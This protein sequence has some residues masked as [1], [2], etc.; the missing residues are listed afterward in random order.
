MARKIRPEDLSE[1]ELRR[2]LIARRRAARQRRLDAFRESG[3]LVDIA[4]MLGT[5]ETE[6]LP[7]IDLP[8]PLAPRDEGAEKAANRKK[9]ADRALLFVEVTAILGLFF[10]LFNGIGAVREL[11]AQVAAALIQPSLTPTPLITVA[12]LPSGHTPPTDPGGAQPNF[13]EIP[14]HLPVDREKF[15]DA[16]YNLPVP[17]PSPEQA[18]RI[19]IPAINIDAPIVQGDGWEQLKQ[20]VAQHLNTARPGED[21]NLVLS[22]HNDI[23][24]EIFRHLDQL[25]PGDEIIVYTN[26]RAYTYIISEEYQVVPPTQIDVMSQTADPTVTLISCYPYL[27]NDKRIVVTASLADG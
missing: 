11:N 13:A 8:D 12:V 3:R 16:F 15:L 24:G 17:T 9:L 26:I 14:A 25:Q 18:I 19:Q 23:F 20:G 4:P 7:N 1:Q 22:A 10:V 5:R 6:A 27:V 2:L 21:G